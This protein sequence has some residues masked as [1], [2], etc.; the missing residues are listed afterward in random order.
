MVENIIG[1]KRISYS[2]FNILLNNGDWKL[3][4]TLNESWDTQRHLAY[5]D[6]LI[7]YN[8][9]SIVEFY[10]DCE[11]FRYVY[12]MDVYITP[13]KDNPSKKYHLQFIK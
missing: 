2:D 11:D 12:R 7:L 10:T 4:N 13:Q 8:L 6:N 3:L 1:I 9:D 5:I